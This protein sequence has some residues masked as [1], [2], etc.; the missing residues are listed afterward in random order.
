MKTTEL[1]V[2]PIGNSRGI[3]LPVATLRKYHIGPSVLMEEREDGLFLRPIPT[4][5]D[6]LSWTETAEQ[7]VLAEENWDDWDAVSADGLEDV[8]WKV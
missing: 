4:S 8:P 3:R 1:K 2:T 5:G 6:K 7:M